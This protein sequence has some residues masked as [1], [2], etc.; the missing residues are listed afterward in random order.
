MSKSLTDQMMD[1]AASFW[2]QPGTIDDLIKRD[3][4]KGV[5]QYGAYQLVSLTLRRGWIMER[6]D[7]VYHC[8]KSTVKEVLNPAGYELHNGPAYKSEFEK[9]FDKWTKQL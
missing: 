8:K 7:E 2:C 1:I 9:A 6:K 4:M 3:F 5:S